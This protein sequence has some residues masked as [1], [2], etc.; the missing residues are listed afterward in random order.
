M[1]SETALDHAVERAVLSAAQAE[2]L[3][4]LARAELEAAR[5]K[6]PPPPPPIP[7]P[8]PASVAA[9]TSD[10]NA[11]DDESLRFITSFADIFVTLG[12]ALFC[13]AAADIA[14]HYAS[15]P[16]KWG[17]VVVLAWGLAEFFTR[18]RR[19]ALPSIVLLLLFAI[20]I[21]KFVL[22]LVTPDNA[23]SYLVR[24]FQYFEGWADIDSRSALIAGLA[25]AAFAALHYW[26]FRVPITIAA[27]AGALC[28]A[29][30]A[31]AHWI[32]PS[33][34]PNVYSSLLLLC[35]IGVFALAMYFDMSDPTRQTRRTDIAF[36]LHLLAAPLI[37][38]P[39]ITAY[40]HHEMLG[41]RAAVGIL[42][43]FLIFGIISLVIDRRA[44]L[45]SGLTYAGIAL[46][47]LLRE[48]GFASL[49]GLTS[50]T[51][52][53]LGLF[54]LLLSAGWQPLRNAILRLLPSAL[55]QR[56]PH[57]RTRLT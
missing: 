6:L 29:L 41:P 18:R 14:S 7:P 50:A 26:R 42:G 5:A 10:A 53:A 40:L 12:I 4:A 11:F 39:L 47:A 17:V 56:L 21:F 48:T 46:S 43:I 27:G 52:L 23:G 32:D 15:D 24:H 33:L 28:I 45:V 57:P 51:L 19:M 20:A 8:I 38:H 37:V 54:I 55:T 44:L 22:G 35:G 49:A 13:G 30:V 2:E 34:G 16:A 36:W 9:V 3:R 1:I 25:T 31:S